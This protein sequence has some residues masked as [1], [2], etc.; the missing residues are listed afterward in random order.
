MHYTLAYFF[1]IGLIYLYFINYVYLENF[2][3]FGL[4]RLYANFYVIVCPQIVVETRN[5]KSI[6]GRIK[7]ETNSW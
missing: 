5:R 7:N 2:L 1:I 6:S 3:T 4:N